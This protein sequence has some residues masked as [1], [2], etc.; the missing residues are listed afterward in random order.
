MCERSALPH[1]RGLTRKAAGKGLARQV[2]WV[3]GV[4]TCD[5]ASQPRRT[6]LFWPPKHRKQLAAPLEQ[7]PGQLV[8][9]WQHKR[10]RLLA[11]ACRLHSAYFL[12]PGAM[13]AM[14]PSSLHS[15]SRRTSSTVAFPASSS[16]AASEG[17]T[18]RGS[19]GSSAAGTAW[20]HQGAECRPVL[21]TAKRWAPSCVRSTRAAAVPTQ[22]LA[23]RVAAVAARRRVITNEPYVSTQ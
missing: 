3:E 21:A 5:V 9:W 14:W 8:Q 12:Q 16:S 13:P 11:T 1:Q 22:Q 18:S 15:P 2:W 19:S 20:Q 17:P 10:P 7:Y 6:L 4:R 23:S